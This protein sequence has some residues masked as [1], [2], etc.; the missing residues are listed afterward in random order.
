[1]MWGAFRALVTKHA[2]L[3][4]KWLKCAGGGC[5]RPT[6]AWGKERGERNTEREI[7][8]AGHGRQSK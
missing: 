7:L 5:L 4:R 8:N 3:V 6:G 1:M 2:E